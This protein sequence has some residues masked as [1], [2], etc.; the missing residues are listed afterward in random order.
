MIGPLGEIP[1]EDCKLFLDFFFVSACLIH[2]PFSMSQIA[3]YIQFYYVFNLLDDGAVAISI[4]VL[5]VMAGRVAMGIILLQALKQVRRATHTVRNPLQN[6]CKS[7]G[8]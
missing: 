5:C 6:H 1:V 8:K 4:L 7:F 3:G 2:F